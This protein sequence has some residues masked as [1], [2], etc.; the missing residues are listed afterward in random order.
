MKSLIIIFSVLIL[1]SCS[2]KRELHE[3]NLN[4]WRDMKIRELDIRLQ[5]LENS[6]VRHSFEESKIDSLRDQLRI[7]K[8]L[9]K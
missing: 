9:Q 4:T 5:I 8:N 2:V 1:S 3:M 6:D 7:I